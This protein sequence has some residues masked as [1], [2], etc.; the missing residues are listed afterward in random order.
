MDDRPIL[1]P[2]FMN[3][4]EVTERVIILEDALKDALN[5]IKKGIFPGRGKLRDK[6]I[7][8]LQEILP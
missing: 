6:E 3:D 5:L 7:Q 4:H 2:G 1:F 8:R